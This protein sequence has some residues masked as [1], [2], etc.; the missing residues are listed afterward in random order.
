MN[1]R[2]DPEAEL[3]RLRAELQQSRDALG[4]FAYVVSHDLRAQLRHILSYS[5]LLKEE[6]GPSLAS[7][8]AQFLGVIHEAAQT[9]G[10]QI[11]GLKAWA[12]LDRV[13]L[14]PLDVNTSALLDE[15]WSALETERAGRMIAWVL[16]ADLP[17]VHADG[18][19]LRQLFTHLLSNACKFTRPRAQ[20]QVSV[21]A[22]PSGDGVIT[23][24]IQDNGVGFA[25]AR[26][27]QLFHVFQRLHSAREFEGLGLGLAMAHKI[28]HRLGGRV[29]LAA[30]PGAGCRA[31]VTLPLAAS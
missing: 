25:V 11:D 8:P 28:A 24:H 23:L 19:L 5:A 21:H 26:Q 17:R 9:L 29:A 2:P 14:Q 20:A 27:D 22:E 6:L 7:E 13:A 30:E 31:S 10:R 3:A 18:T 15:V 4:E 16:P 12:Q 1:T